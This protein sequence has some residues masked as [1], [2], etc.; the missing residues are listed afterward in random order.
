MDARYTRCSTTQARSSLLCLCVFHIVFLG[1]NILS[2]LL[3][4][5]GLAPTLMVARVAL[6]SPDTVVHANSGGMSDLEFQAQSVGLGTSHIFGAHPRAGELD[7]GSKL[8]GA[9]EKRERSE[10]LMKL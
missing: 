10:T 1:V 7:S 9:D 6:A 8:S 3:A 2:C 4:F 5:Q